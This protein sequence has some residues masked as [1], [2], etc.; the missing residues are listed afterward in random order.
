M[1]ITNNMIPSQPNSPEMEDMS[2]NSLNIRIAEAINELEG[3]LENGIN[4]SRDKISA[5]VSELQ[6]DHDLIL[7]NY[8]KVDGYSGDASGTIYY[9]RK[10]LSHPVIRELGLFPKS[11]FPEMK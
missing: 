8:G 2:D 3:I 7:R 10:A 4:G 11:V 9:I 6:N 1:L 5:L